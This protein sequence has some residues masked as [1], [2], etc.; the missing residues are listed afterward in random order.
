MRLRYLGLRRALLHCLYLQ[1]CVWLGWRG[2]HNF[3]VQ[4]GYVLEPRDVLLEGDFLSVASY[5]GPSSIL[6]LGANLVPCHVMQPVKPCMLDWK[7]VGKVFIF[8]LMGSDGQASYSMWV[9]LQQ[10]SVGILLSLGKHGW[11][12]ANFPLLLLVFV[13]TKGVVLHYV[14]IF[15]CRQVMT[16][17]LASVL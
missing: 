14:T 15:A 9:A 10:F 5:R 11:I 4:L 12:W 17:P 8:M 2:G 6:P 3:T 13:C 16:K 7:K 1:P